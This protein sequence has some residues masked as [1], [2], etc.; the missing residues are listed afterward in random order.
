LITSAR[1]C[2]VRIGEHKLA[3]P[4]AYARQVHQLSDLRRAPRAPAT[5]LG[6]FAVRSQVIPI[7]T[8]EPLLGLPARQHDLAMQIEFDRKSFGFG[9]DEVLGFLGLEP[10]TAM[11]SPLDS[12]CDGAARFQQTNAPLLDLPRLMRSLSSAFNKEEVYL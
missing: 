1:A 12:I 5:L 8:L 7:V 10:A 4:G 9:I 6:L 11:P 2:F 3:I